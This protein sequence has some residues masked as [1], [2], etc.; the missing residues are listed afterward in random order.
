[1]S[2]K[3]NNS[4][5]VAALISDVKSINHPLARFSKPARRIHADALVYEASEDDLQRN[6]QSPTGG[7][8]RTGLWREIVSEL[9]HLE[10]TTV[11]WALQAANPADVGPQELQ[12][13]IDSERNVRA[14]GEVATEELME[15]LQC[16]HQYYA[17]GTITVEPCDVCQSHYFAVMTA[18]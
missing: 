5:V 4:V 7:L 12:R 9:M 11:Y 16:S 3:I 18:N 8:K 13:L 14:C 10:A 2:L 17:C 6:D 15:C 1:M